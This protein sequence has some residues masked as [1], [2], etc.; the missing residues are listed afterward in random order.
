MLSTGLTGAPPSGFVEPEPL[1]F[2]VDDIRVKKLVEIGDS[3]F[4]L[5]V[6]Y[7][8]T[9]GDRFA[10]HPCKISLYSYGT[11]VPQAGKQ[12]PSADWWLPNPDKD[13]GTSLT[14][15]HA[16]N[17]SVLS[18]VSVPVTRPCTLETCPWPKQL[19]VRDT[20]QLTIKQSVSFDLSKFP[21]DRCVACVLR[22]ES[23]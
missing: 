5:R 15:T 11:G 8:I 2:H 16:T 6:W 1:V 12:V 17:L 21:F 18:A 20:I 4:T 10:V 9:W 19:L 13:S 23:K 3:S 22:R 14:F 7:N